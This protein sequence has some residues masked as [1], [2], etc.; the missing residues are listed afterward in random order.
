MH[1]RRL[2]VCCDGPCLWQKQNRAS[3]EQVWFTGVHSNVGCGYADTGSSYVV[4]DWMIER[5]RRHGLEFDCEYLLKAVKPNPEAALRNSKTG[6]HKIFQDALRVH[7]SPGT[8]EFLH[9]T[10][11]A[12]RN[13]LAACQPRELSKYPG[14][15]AINL[16]ELLHS[17][18]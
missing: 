9:P 5:S 7:N 6:L 18:I 2:I 15:P 10:V 1:L 17:R 16:Q 14:T 12:R 13:R 3:P 4:L 8:S 11:L